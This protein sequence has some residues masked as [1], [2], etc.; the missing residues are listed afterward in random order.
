MKNNPENLKKGSKIV[1]SYYSRSDYQECWGV[2]IVTKIMKTKVHVSF[3][4]AIREHN[5]EAVYGMSTFKNFTEKV[6]FRKTEHKK[7]Y[8]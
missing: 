4:D 8:R 1:D 6:D 2:G 3:P 5:K 7:L